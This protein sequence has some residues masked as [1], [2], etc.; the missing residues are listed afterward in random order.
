MEQAANAAS[1][2][3][4]L[5][6]PYGGQQ[7]MTGFNP[8]DP[9]GMHG[10]AAPQSSAGA[11]PYGDNPFFSSKGFNLSQGMQSYI[12]QIPG[13]QQRSLDSLR[14]YL[15]QL[16]QGNVRQ[17]Q[18]GAQLYNPDDPMMAS[19]A[20]MNAEQGARDTSMNVL[21][22]ATAD[23]NAQYEDWLHGLLSQYYGVQGQPK[24]KQSNGLG[25]I[26]GQILGAGLGYLGL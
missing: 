15:S 23:S 17:A 25:G 3:L 5:Q 6:S 2:Q 16:G 19:Y 14:S 10:G 4:Q 12:G 8:F 1:N 20:R 13:Q 18:L 11:N 7:A 26:G 22:K 21:G 24:Q 9:R